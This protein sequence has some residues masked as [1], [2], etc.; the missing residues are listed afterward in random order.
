MI[1]ITWFG[2]ACFGVTEDGY[3]M[4]IDPYDPGNGRPQ[5]NLEANEV[6]VSHTHGDHNYLEGVKISAKSDS[7]FKV[8][9]VDSFHDDEGG[10]SK[11]KNLIHVIEANGKRIVHLGDLGH[12]LDAE[13]I[14]KIGRVDLLMIPVGGYY[15]IDAAQAKE[16]V[17]ELNPNV[18]IPMH[19]AFSDGAVIAKVDAFL[20]LMGD[21]EI[22]D[23]DSSRYELEGGAKK[24]VVMK[25]EYPFV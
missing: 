1:K 22:D 6:L 20:K 8:N 7:P 2:H 21:W 4:V 9:T 14:R 10:A 18:V 12:T 24:I 19:Y 16:V 3:T 11:G 13:A 17:S 15:T 5:L 25:P 23:T